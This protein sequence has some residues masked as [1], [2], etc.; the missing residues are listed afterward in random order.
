MEFN[1][2]K[3]K[4]NILNPIQ[5]GGKEH[6]INAQN[7]VWSELRIQTRVQ[8]KKFIPGSKENRHFTVE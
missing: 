7:A 3:R 4:M 1:K 6:K 2:C 5:A 8:L